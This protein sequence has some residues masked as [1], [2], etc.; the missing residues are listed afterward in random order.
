MGT[1]NKTTPLI[2]PKPA[3]AQHQAQEPQKAVDADPQRRQA[4]DKPVTEQVSAE[5]PN[6]RS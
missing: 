1:D 5:K 3:P 2:T 6:Q 4:G